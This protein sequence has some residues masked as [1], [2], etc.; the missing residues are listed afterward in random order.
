[1][2][3]SIILLLLALTTVCTACMQLM[4]RKSIKD[5]WGGM[6]TLRSGLQVSQ[7]SEAPPLAPICPSCGGRWSKWSDPAALMKRQELVL[8]PERPWMLPA[9]MPTDRVILRHEQQR[10]CTE[11][12]YAERK[13]VA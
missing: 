4:C 11:C 8:D 6:D 10:E 5:V 9:G 2:A 3:T 13:T 12:G 7:R 1:M